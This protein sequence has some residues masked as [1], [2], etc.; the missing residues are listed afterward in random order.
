M[1]N[2]GQISLKWMVLSIYDLVW[3]QQEPAFSIMF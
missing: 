2:L 3:I 1:G